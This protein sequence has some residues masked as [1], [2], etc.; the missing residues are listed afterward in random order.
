MSLVCRSCGRY[1]ARRFEVLVRERARSQTYYAAQV[2][3]SCML[4]FEAMLDGVSPPK[5]AWVEQPL[6]PEYQRA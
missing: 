5:H 4:A 6:L 3:Q 1:R 2:C